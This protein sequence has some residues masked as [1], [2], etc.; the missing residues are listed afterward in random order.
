[1]P[2]WRTISIVA[3]TTL[4]F[5]F[6]MVQVFNTETAFG[7]AD[8]YQ[9]FLISKYAF[10]HPDLFI[11]H[12]GKPV[13]TL[14]SSVFS[15]AGFAGMKVFQILVILGTGLCATRI[16]KQL[17]Y[18]LS[19]I[20]VPLVLFT[21]IFFQCAFSG[22]TEP[23]FAL[24]LLGS[25]ALFMSKRFRTAAILL[26]FIPLVRT[27]GIMMLPLLG[28]ALA[29]LKQ[30]KS[31]PWLATGI[32]FYSLLGLL[33]HHHDL[34]W[35]WSN[36]PYSGNNATYGSGEF[37]RYISSFD[38][39][40]G[41]PLM[42]ATV[43]GLVFVVV[44]VIKKPA[45]SEVVHWMLI[46]GAFLGY[47]LVHSFLWAK[48]SSGSLGLLRIMAAV[49]PLAALLAV[50]GIEGILFK[51]RDRS[52]VVVIAGTA[53][54]ATTI[55]FTWQAN[56]GPNVLN[57]E[58]QGMQYASD[59]IDYHDADAKVF[60]YNPAFCFFNERDLFSYEK[61][62]WASGVTEEF[63]PGSYVVWDAHFGANEGATQ[64]TKLLFHPNL[65]FRYQY[66]PPDNEVVLN[67]VPYEVLVFEAFEQ[68]QTKL[69]TIT[70]F[71]E[72][73][74]QALDSGST[75][76]THRIL[77]GNAAS[78]NQSYR[79]ND[80]AQFLEGTNRALDPLTNYRYSFVHATAN[81]YVE[82]PEDLKD[83]YLVI[84]TELNGELLDY[85]P[86][87]PDSTAAANTWLE[88]TNDFLI[89]PIRDPGAN[90]KVYL[91]YN[92]Q[93]EIYVDDFTVKLSSRQPH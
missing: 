58:E 67:D 84:A 71:E 15:Q 51:F 80:D 1:M 75:W 34:L 12:W 48:G 41:W 45:R 47:F 81:I 87:Q 46:T 14:L 65:E 52:V 83:T 25:I 40:L 26:S 76:S 56:N 68:S 89:S 13:F 16:L 42:V 59:W 38:E 2:S 77:T 19:P 50:V 7:G 11:H 27:E 90:F 21:P 55:G 17:N 5:M 66:L 28:L 72:G 79:M 53:I 22:L 73:F 69:S 9:H 49:S 92:G 74:E 82:D 60:F 70:L 37:L 78:G 63:S 43:L 31:L 35:L 10:A 93:D 3:L 86:I 91:W 44:R 85:H 62:G 29:L 64:A 36:N 61:S 24:I 88:F 30:Y 8:S 18:R 39:W 54:C 33:F 23:L 4:S 57:F 32:V 20:A 6:M